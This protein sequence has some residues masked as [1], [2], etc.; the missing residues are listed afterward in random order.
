[1]KANLRTLGAIA[2]P[3]DTIMVGLNRTLTDL[4]LAELQQDFSDF[5]E[6]TGVHIALVE[7]VSALVV[8]QPEGE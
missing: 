3:G 7:D 2:R 1:V 4:E 6:T 8:I 5:T